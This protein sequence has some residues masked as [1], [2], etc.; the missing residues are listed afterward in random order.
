MNGII[1]SSE[2]SETGRRWS[3]PG[4]GTT[5]GRSMA[6]LQSISV[7]RPC[8]FCGKVFTGRQYPSEKNPPRFCSKDCFRQFHSPDPL[9]R[10]WAKVNKN[11][12]IPE[13][14]PD[15]GPCWLWT[16][17][18]TKGYGQ[19]RLNGRMVYAYTFAYEQ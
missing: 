17:A 6:Q 1:S 3:A 8:E 2:Y 11:G 7:T 14:R 15:L 19:F 4:L 12:P 18:L 16:A 10:F 5:E 9:V 13:H